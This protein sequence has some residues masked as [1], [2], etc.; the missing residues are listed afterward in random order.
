MHGVFLF[1]KKSGKF[2][3]IDVE[4][5]FYVGTMLLI[6]FSG[7]AK[8]PRETSCVYGKDFLAFFYAAIY[9][10]FFNSQHHLTRI[11]GV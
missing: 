2:S 11:D 6:Q 9:A 10:A 3:S 8:P 1:N 7:F 4:P 5:I